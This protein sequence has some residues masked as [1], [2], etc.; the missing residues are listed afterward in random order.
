QIWITPDEDGAPPRYGQKTA[1]EIAA[2]PDGL[3]ALFGGETG[4][5][6]RQDAQVWL[7]KLPAGGSVAFEHEAS[8][9]AWI[10]MVRGSVTVLGESLQTGDGAAIDGAERFV[11]AAGEDAEFLLFSLR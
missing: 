10:Q 6:I 2:R 4:L 8:R 1:V 9:G 11:I 5:P 7:G 3:T